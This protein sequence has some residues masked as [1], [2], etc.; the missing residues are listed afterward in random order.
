MPDNE[1]KAAGERRPLVFVDIGA[2]DGSSVAAA[3]EGGYRFDRIVSAEPDPDMIAHLSQ[4]FAS[5]IEAGRYT[6][7]PVGISDHAGAARL[8][9]DNSRG[10]ASIIEGKFAAADRGGREIQLIDWPRF[11]ADYGLE[12]ARLW[13]KIN[14][15]GA[16]VAIIDSILAHGHRNIESLVVYFDI[17]K[18]PF[19]AW[20]KWRTLR[21]ARK[22]GLPLLL[23]E[24]ILVKRGPRPRLHN[25]FSSFAD[26]KSPPLA[27]VPAPLSKLVRMHYLDIV[28]ACG[29]R[30]DLFKRAR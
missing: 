28:S 21:A 24:D 17:V 9:G 14:A 18:S 30:L 22:A 3:V 25:W 29:I 26:L 10:G 1:S 23:A 5:L 12:D 11:L 6:I 13:V 16:E 19:G 4:R 20:A 2:H 8:F 15:E 27:P 7:A